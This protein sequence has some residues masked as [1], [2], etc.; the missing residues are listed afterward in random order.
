MCIRDSPYTT[1]VPRGSIERGHALAIKLC[2]S[3]HGEDLRGI[4]PTP[5]IA[6]RS[7]SYVLRQ[8]FA[9]KTGTRSSTA[10]APMRMAASTLSLDDMIAA[11]AYAGTLKP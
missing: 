6:G 11:A 9:F 5:P 2:A 10:G 1:Y 3:C 8:L 7:P 4:G